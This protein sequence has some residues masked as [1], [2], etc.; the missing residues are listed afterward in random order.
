LEAVL[1][2]KLLQTMVVLEEAQV[3]VR[4]ALREQEHLDKEIMAA[5]KEQYVL[6]AVEVL[7][8]LEVLEVVMILAV[9]EMEL[10]LLYLVLL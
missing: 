9:E 8:R 10:H 6:V 5:L 4:A 7:V 2:V 3:K 1:V